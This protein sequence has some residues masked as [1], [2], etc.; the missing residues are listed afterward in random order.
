MTHDQQF[1]I[2]ENTE[3]FTLTANDIFVVK[4]KKHCKYV[5]SSLVTL[6]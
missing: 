1:Y 2:K 5:S 6:E 3:T 4:N